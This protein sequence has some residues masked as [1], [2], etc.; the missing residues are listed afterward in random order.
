MIPELSFFRRNKINYIIQLVFHAIKCCALI[1]ISIQYYNNVLQK[2]MLE[3]FTNT[4]STGYNQISSGRQSSL[5]GTTIRK[6]LHPEG[7]AMI[8]S[9]KALECLSL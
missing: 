2:W 3:V 5:K 6:E 1:F 9:T 8:S 4:F 7:S